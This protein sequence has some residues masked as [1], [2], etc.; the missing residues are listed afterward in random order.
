MADLGIRGGV[1]FLLLL[2]GRIRTGVEC[3]AEVR[4]VPI[5]AYDIGVESNELVLFDHVGRG[6]LEPGACA[7]AGVEEAGFGVFAVVFDDGLVED[8]P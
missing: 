4:V 6:F 8:T 5:T 1:F 3:A 2:R 7:G